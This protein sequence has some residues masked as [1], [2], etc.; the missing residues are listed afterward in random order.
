MPAISMSRSMSFRLSMELPSVAAGLQ[1]LGHQRTGEGCDNGPM[2]E[3]EKALD[4]RIV[5]E[6][7]KPEIWRTLRVPA[8]VRLNDLHEAIQRA[9]G[10]ENR[11]LHLFHPGGA[12][13]RARPIA[14]DNESA[15]ELGM[16]SAVGMAMARLLSGEG[17]RLE[18]EYDLGDSWI[19][20]IEVT[21]HA[22]VP[23]GQISC[24]G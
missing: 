24:L 10:W 19:H 22:L 2:P 9:F 12:F 15:D 17:N 13:G 4:L 18:Y 21:G 8:S 3:T 14:G 11:H 20:S 5:L 23:A 1:V 6:G 7:S 16:E